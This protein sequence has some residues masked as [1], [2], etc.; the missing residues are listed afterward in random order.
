MHKKK[1]RGDN[2]KP[3]SL[4]TFQA[5]TECFMASD[6]GIRENVKEETKLAVSENYVNIRYGNSQIIEDALAYIYDYVSAVTLL[7]IVVD[8][9]VQV[10]S[11][12]T[13][14]DRVG[15]YAGMKSP[16]VAHRC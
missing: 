2:G 8:L 7:Q 16:T 5:H 13:L 1:E 6:C 14:I 11:R 10:V 3:F 15:L 4:F 12:H 9:A